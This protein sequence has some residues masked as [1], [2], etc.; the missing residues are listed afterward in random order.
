[1]IS[2]LTTLLLTA[3]LLAPA[4]AM[5]ATQRLSVGTAGEPAAGASGGAAVSATGR[6]VAFASEAPNL[7]GG[8]ANGVA[9]V[10]VRDRTAGTTSRVSV[11]TDGAEGTGLSTAPSVSAD[12]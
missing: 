12:G 6:F 4:A 11:S 3:A 10:F 1:M 2:R 7:V 9:D 5:A 8:D